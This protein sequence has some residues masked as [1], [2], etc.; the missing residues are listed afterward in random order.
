MN[1][2]HIRPVNHLFDEVLRKGHID[3]RV[4]HDD[5][6][7]VVKYRPRLI[8]K[9]TEEVYTI[10]VVVENKKTKEVHP[11]HHIDRAGR[12]FNHVLKDVLHHLHTKHGVKVCVEKLH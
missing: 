6:N 1:E 12:A 3:F 4:L 9:G 10:E 5:D 7:H 11:P 2:K 8:Q